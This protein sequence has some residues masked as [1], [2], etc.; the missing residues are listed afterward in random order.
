[1]AG[2]DDLQQLSSKEL[3]D[4]AVR[5]AVRR[6][7]IKFLWNLLTRIPAAEAT[8]GKVGESEADIKWVLPLIDDYVHAGDGDLAE[9]LRPFYL[10]YLVKHS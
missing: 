10:D 6:G 3:H 4:R 8:A 9:A 2:N 5:L 1:M 7:D